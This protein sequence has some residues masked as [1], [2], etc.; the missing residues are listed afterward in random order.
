MSTLSVADWRIRSPASESFSRVPLESDM[1][2]ATAPVLMAKKTAPATSTPTSCIVPMSS[3]CGPPAISWCTSPAAMTASRYWET[4]KATNLG[5][6]RWAT[7]AATDPSPCATAAGIAPKVSRI[8]K[9]KVVEGATSPW[10]G[11]SRIG[12]SSPTSTAPTRIARRG[13]GSLTRAGSCGA[14]AAST[15]TPPRMTAAT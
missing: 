14:M 3:L 10:P 6:R 9:V 13:S 7:S 11:P 8:A 1:A 4:L 5:R 2:T 15:A 12:T